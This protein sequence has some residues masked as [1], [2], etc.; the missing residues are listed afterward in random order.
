MIGNTRHQHSLLSDF[1]KNTV[2]LAY[3]YPIY[4]I[5]ARL[6]EKRPAIL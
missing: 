5:S 4:V 1:R 3:G 6:A 2:L